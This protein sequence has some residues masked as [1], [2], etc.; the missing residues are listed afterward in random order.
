MSHRP[1]RLRPRPASTPKLPAAARTSKPSAPRSIKWLE[2][3][4]FYRAGLGL[5]PVRD[6][7]DLSSGA[8][9]HAHYL[10]LN[11]G[12]D[13]RTARPMSGDAY[14]EKPGRSGYSENGAHAAQNL[15]LAWGCSSYDADQQIDRWIEG[16]FHRV[17]VFDPLLAEVG[18][19]E[20]SSGGC[21]VATLRLPPTP[22][23]SQTYP[24]AIEF[25]PDGATVALDWIG[26]EA[27]DPLASC[28]GYSRPVGLPITLQVG[29]LV[30]SKLSAHSLTE[31]GKPIEHC[32]FD[33]PTYLNPVPAYQKFGYWNLRDEGAVVIVPREP[34]RPGS[35]YAVSITA[36]NKT[37]A[38]SFKVADTRT[39]FTSIAR[40]ATP[41][42]TAPPAT[43]APAAEPAATGPAATEPP[44]TEPLEATPLEITPAPTTS[45]KPRRTARATHRAT[46]VAIA[47]RFVPERPAS[48]MPTMS[49]R[50][51]GTPAAAGSSTGWLAILNLYRTR[52]N[53]PPV[54]EDPALSSGCFAHS[55]YLVTN[56]EPMFARNIN[57]GSLL[58]TEDESK[59]GYSAEGLKAARA[60]DVMFQ[61]KRTFTSEQRMTRAIQSWIAGPFHRPQIVNPNL[62]QVGYGEYCGEIVCAASL[63]WRSDLPLT[64]AGGGHPFASPIEVPPD[65]ATVKPGGYSGEWPNPVSSCPGY[66]KDAPAITLQLGV[67][68]PA[69]ITD[70]SLTQTSGA[71][72]GTKIGTCPYDSR[73]YTNPDPG[74]QEHGRAVLKS[75]GQVVMM[76]RDPLIGG[77]SYRVAM[78]VNGKQYSWSFTAAP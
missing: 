66:P 50:A 30:D 29:R 58:H 69:T 14:E 63:D 4:N 74:T 42:T 60:S 70:G 27:P 3:L 46:P 24:R 45:P 40:L 16:P 31:N 21:W 20:A 23:E 38:W 12:E 78:T 7:P 1:R 17:A 57:L 51:E 55:K 10:I 61:G 64:P 39:T 71:A 65:G 19:G 2:R 8:A 67:W 35:R 44:A 49:P 56:Y 54:D 41:P 36:D 34:L 77:E 52:L 26:L 9:A 33:A 37:Y 15:Q 13:I 73:S 59:P 43:E 25:P 48:A 76:V 5:D 28:P 47:P 53:V 72:A 68:V 62:K 32:A 18:Y 6:N 75:F 22:E 11:F